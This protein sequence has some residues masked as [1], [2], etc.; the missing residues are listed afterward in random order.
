MR[1]TLNLGMPPG[2]EGDQRPQARGRDADA[3]CGS[4]S[5]QQQRFNQQLLRQPSPIGA[6]G[7]SHRELAAP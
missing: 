2:I 7:A 1:A 6:E 4:G 5:G 3:Q